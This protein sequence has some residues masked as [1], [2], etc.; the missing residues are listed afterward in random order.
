MAGFTKNELEAINANPTTDELD[1]F[2]A[3]FKSTYSTT[4]VQD[5]EDGQEQFD[6][7]PSE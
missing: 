5:S 3:T 1:A 6:I 4:R 2:R 7:N